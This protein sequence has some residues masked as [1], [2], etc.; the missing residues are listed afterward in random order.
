MAGVVGVVH[1]KG[2]EGNIVKISPKSE[3]CIILRGLKLYLCSC[4]QHWGYRL[5][6]AGGCGSHCSCI[7][8][9]KAI[10]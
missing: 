5:G 1:V 3:V 7:S 4:R 9:I 6:G 2:M 8:H 10:K